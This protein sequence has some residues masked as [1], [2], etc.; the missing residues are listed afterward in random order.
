MEFGGGWLEAEDG[1]ELEPELEL[2]LAMAIWFW[3]AWGGEDWFWP[4]GDLA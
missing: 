2:G 4:S 1:V 3:F